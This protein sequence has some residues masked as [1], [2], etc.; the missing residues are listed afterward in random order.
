[1]VT[2]NSPARQTLALQVAQDIRQHIE[3]RIL[4]PGQR[5]PSISNLCDQYGVSTITVRAA[6]RELILKGYLESRPRSGTYVCARRE[7]APTLAG[8]KAVALLVPTWDNPFWTEM[9]RGVEDECR[10]QGYRLVLAHSDRDLEREARQMEELSREVAGLLIV[11]ISASGNYPAYAGLLERHVPFVFI[12]R[13]VEKLAVPVV[14]TDNEEGGYLLASHLLSLGRRRI[15]VLS[16]GDATSIHERIRGYQ[17]ALR[18]HGVPFS[19]SLV[20]YSRAFGSAAGY[21]LTKNLLSRRRDSEPF[22]IFAINDGV[23]RGCY[24]ALKEEGLRIPEDAAV[25]GFDNIFAP[26][27]DPPL[28]TIL[29]DTRTMGAAAA[30]LLL[31]AIRYGKRLDRKVERLKPEMVVRHSSDPNSDFSLHEHIAQAVGDNG[32]ALVES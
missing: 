20:F 31:E 10:A 22:G 25:V 17:R 18:E 5:L 9:I 4:A 24:A 32:M 15:Y 21:L 14:A 13:Y 6:L 23:A 28:T 2:K 27:L 8:H 12:D 29:Q 19:A 11:P 1:M 30:R 3:R 7:Q 16:E 26:F